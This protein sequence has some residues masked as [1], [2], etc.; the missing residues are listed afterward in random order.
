MVESFNGGSLEGKK[1][2]EFE[3]VVQKYATKLGG[4]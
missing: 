1:A 3:L 2:S 4:N